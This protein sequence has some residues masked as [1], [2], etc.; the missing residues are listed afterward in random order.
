MR[1]AIIF[2][3]AS[4]EH[5]ESVRAARTL[6]QEA[7]MAGL[8]Q[9]YDFIYFY[10]SKQNHWA[11]AKDSK[12]I[13]SGQSRNK[14]SY[15][16]DNRMLDLKK[17]DVI[18]NTM[19]GCCGE[20]GNI[21]GLA[22][23]IGIPI[24]GCDILSSALTLDKHLS[25]ILA[26]G[27]DIP[28]VDFIYVDKNCP[29]E[30]IVSDIRQTVAFPCF[31]KPINLGT[32]AY[33]FKAHDEA[34]FYHKWEQTVQQNNL[35]NKYLIE[36][37][38]P[39]IEVRIFAYQDIRG[40]LHLNDKYTTKLKEEILDTGG[41]LFDHVSNNLSSEIRSKMKQYAANIF[42]LFK[43]KDYARIDFFVDKVTKQIYFNEAN[44][45]PFISPYN[46]ELMEQDGITYADFIDLMI[47]RNSRT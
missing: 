44:T 6:Y 43:M 36:K 15:Y 34:E 9:K 31:V 47:R 13:I 1:V 23:I 22:N 29:P 2:G 3:G 38:I 45:Q 11:N 25:K 42:R 10:L 28:V 18:Y 41:V 33:V 37:F 39:N 16:N 21:M 17:V 46:I 26:S 5:Q 19:M 14:V 40:K 35:S 32:C 12:A 20:N 4:P 27:I 8:I 24:I 7:I 30:E